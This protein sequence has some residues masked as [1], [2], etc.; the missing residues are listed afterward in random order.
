MADSDEMSFFYG[1]RI[2]DKFKWQTNRFDGLGDP[3]AHLKVFLSVAKSWQLVDN[4]MGQAFVL[5]LSGIVLRWLAQIQSIT[6]EKGG[7]VDMIGAEDNLEI[8]EEVIDDL[9][10][11]VIALSAREQIKEHTFLIYIGSD[12]EEDESDLTQ[13][14]VDNN[15]SNPIEIFWSIRSKYYECLDV[16]E[17]R[18]PDEEPDEEPDDETSEGKIS[19][20]DDDDDDDDEDKD[21][22]LNYDE[23][24][25]SDDNYPDWDDYLRPKN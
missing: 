10:R 3:K 7:L 9:H 4:Q 17:F 23:E 20:D 8:V 18:G 22:D 14:R 5:T 12:I 19:G 11:A 1:A 24:D 13:L 21:E 6:Q 2:L 25:D 16:G 15:G